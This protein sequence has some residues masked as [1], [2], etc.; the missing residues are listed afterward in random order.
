MTVLGL[1][2]LYCVE[3]I[4]EAMQPELTGTRRLDRTMLFGGGIF[5]IGWTDL[6]VGIGHLDD[7]LALTLVTLA[8]WAL[9]ANVPASPGSASA[10]RWTRSPGRWCSWR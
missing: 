1:V 8:V 9:T 2:V 10:S 4:A 3:R 6:S 7:A 5:M